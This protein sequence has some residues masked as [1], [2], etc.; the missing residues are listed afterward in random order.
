M[1]Y[2]KITTGFVVQNYD[3]D[4]RCISQEFVA[5]QH[6]DCEDEYGEKREP[7]ENEVDCP[8]DMVQP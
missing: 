7:S 3:D 4:G 8:F 2:N 5:C 1:A 6:S